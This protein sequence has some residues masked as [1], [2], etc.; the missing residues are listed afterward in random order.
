[1][2]TLPPSVNGI[3]AETTRYIALR[4]ALA[5]IRA[6]TS[7]VVTDFQTILP[8][9]LIPLQSSD[10]RVRSAVMDCV[11]TLAAAVSKPTSVYA[12]DAVYGPASGELIAKF[13]RKYIPKVWL[14]V[15]LKYLEWPDELH[16]LQ[17]LAGN[18]DHLVNDPDHFA[19]FSIESLSPSKAEVR[20]ETRYIFSY[21]A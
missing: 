4:H 15:E 13:F 5:F 20:K 9:F 10:R 14:L 1:M 17:L 12:Y 7:D 6:K 16:L 8:S 11:A 18:S 3:D 2:W 21:F 19:T